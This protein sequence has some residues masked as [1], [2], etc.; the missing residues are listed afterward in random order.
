MILTCPNCAT[1]YLVADT[2]IGPAGRT[3]RCSACQHS[4]HVAPPES[5]HR[6]LVA[7]LE[8]ADTPP[9]PI[10]DRP[11]EPMTGWTPAA[12]W[13]PAEGTQ[14]RRRYRRNPARL[15]TAGA[16]SAAVLLLG[17][18]MLTWRDSLGLGATRAAIGLGS[19]A[20]AA[21]A[22]PLTVEVATLPPA[23]LLANGDIEQPL[24][25]RIAN[26]TASRQPVP[27]VRALMLDA[28]NAL[29]YSWKIEPGV[30]ELPPRGSALVETRAVNFPTDPRPVGLRLEF[31]DRQG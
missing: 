31:A 17:F 11:A 20:L 12:D 24:V 7:R 4:W 13:M 19:S 22:S 1:R 29:V 16:I 10:P 14:T 15:Y 3:V 5:A 30:A 9:P 23:R 26:P 25:A 21:H 18:N 28:D 2:A 6:D 8:P 27:P